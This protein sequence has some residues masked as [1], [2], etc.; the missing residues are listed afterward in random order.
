[1]ENSNGV[2]V[3]KFEK[4]LKTYAIVTNAINAVF[5]IMLTIGFVKFGIKEGWGKLV[6]LGDE[7]RVTALVLYEL[8]TIAS[9]IW[10]LIVR[11]KRIKQTSSSK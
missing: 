4:T 10:W 11:H 2:S 6:A 7:I 8:I 1:M 9:T 3:S 5:V